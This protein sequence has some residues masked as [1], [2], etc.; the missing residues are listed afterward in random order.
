MLNIQPVSALAVW[1]SGHVS[2]GGV[3]SFTERI[4]LQTVMFTPSL[5]VR[6]MIIDP[7]STIV[8]AIGSWVILVTAQLSVAVA[9]PV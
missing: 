2:S 9:K 4:K 1:S 8:P 3:M 7:V 6:V 5:A